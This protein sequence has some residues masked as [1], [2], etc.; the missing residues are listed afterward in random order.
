MKV[1]KIIPS[2]CTDGK[3][4][5]NH[6]GRNI[7]L[8]SQKQSVMTFDVGTSHQKHIVTTSDT[9]AELVAITMKPC[10]MCHSVV[11]VY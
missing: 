3:V 10:E 11:D 7:I 2:T 6:V 9:K 8:G 5:I 1:V 4:K